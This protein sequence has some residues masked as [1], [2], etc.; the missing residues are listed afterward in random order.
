MTAG[1]RWGDL[2]ARVLTGGILAVV[3]VA[4]MVAG[5]TVFLFVAALV[6]GIMVWEVAAMA[7][8]DGDYRAVLPGLL[9]TAVVMLAPSIDP[10]WRLPLALIP[11]IVGAVLLTRHRT[12]FFVY[13]LAIQVAGHGLTSF[14]DEHGF[15]W[16]LWLVLVVVVTDIAGYFAGRHFGGP[17]F[18]P[19][20]S[21]N[22]TWTGTAAG[23]IAAALVGAA[24]LAFTEAGRDIIWISMV[25]SFASQMG[26][27]AESALK[28]RTGVKDSSALLPG[29]GGL[30]DRFDGLLG[31]SLFLLLLSLV[32]PVPGLV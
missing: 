23:W 30:Y 6:C 12:L 1:S 29:H 27:A 24:F 2:R 5:G 21:P 11:P 32:T 18:W 9:A 13:A 15:L 25:L 7:A 16:L 28:R 3:G 10:N 20:V 26:D 19:A 31:A 8:P 14:R 4:A 17:K 22:K